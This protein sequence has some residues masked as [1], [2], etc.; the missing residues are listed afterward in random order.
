MEHRGDPA[1][2][3]VVM[4]AAAVSAYSF[5]SA[6]G[7]FFFVRCEHLVTRVAVMIFADAA[8]GAEFSPKIFDLRYQAG[9]PA[10]AALQ[11]A[12]AQPLPWWLLRW[13]EKPGL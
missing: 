3:F 8:C 4:K 12:F 7:F 5:L 9:E 6:P 13:N 1:P 10:Q 11:S 2:A